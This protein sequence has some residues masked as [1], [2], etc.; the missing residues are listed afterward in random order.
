MPPPSSGPYL[1]IMKMMHTIESIMMCPA[2]MLAKRRMV[3]DTGF[4]RALNT[5]MTGIMGLRNTG[6]SGLNISL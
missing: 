1:A 4:M 6:T 2:S 3:R 5:S